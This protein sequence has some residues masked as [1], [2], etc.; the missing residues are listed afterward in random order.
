M[1]TREPQPRRRHAAF[2][3]GLK[4]FV[5]GGYGNEIQT[6]DIETLDISSGRWEQPQPLQG[7]LPDRLEGMAVTSDGEMAYTFGGYRGSTRINSVYEINPRTLKCEE[8]LPVSSYSPTG[9]S[10]SAIV[11]FNRKLIVYG[12]NTDQGRS[13]D[14][15]VFDLRKSECIG[16]AGLFMSGV[17]YTRGGIF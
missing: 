12:G 3:V 11:C 7:S 13:D 2:G 16:T 9:M 4:H 1:A 10:S 5:W 14:L 6:K 17:R 8:I 15:L